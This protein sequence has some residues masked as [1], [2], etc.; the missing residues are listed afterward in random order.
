M[1]FSDFYMPSTAAG[2]TWRVSYHKPQ[3]GPGVICA[4]EGESEVN[5]G[6]RIFKTVIFQSRY[7]RHPLTGRA[8]KR[9]VVCALCELLV[10]LEADGFISH[11]DAIKRVAQAQELLS[12][13]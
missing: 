12:S 11:A 2:L 8:T 6:I 1:A 10:S 5:D 3:R 13:I 7:K 9:A 4:S